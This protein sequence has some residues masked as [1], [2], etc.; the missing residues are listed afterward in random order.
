MKTELSKEEKALGAIWKV[1]DI[2]MLGQKHLARIHDILAVR[3]GIVGHSK[4]Q[5]L[6]REDDFRDMVLAYIKDQQEF[7]S[8]SVTNAQYAGATAFIKDV[9]KAALPT[10]TV[11]DQLSAAGRDLAAEPLPY[12]I[13][14][15]RSVK[16]GKDIWKADDGS[17][18]SFAVFDDKVIWLSG[19]DG[20]GNFTWTR[21]IF[22]QLIFAYMTHVFGEGSTNSYRFGKCIENLLSG[23]G[24]AVNG[25][26]VP[27]PKQPDVHNWSPKPDSLGRIQALAALAKESNYIKAVHP[28]T[29]PTDATDYYTMF[30]PKKHAYSRGSVLTN[31][32]NIMTVKAVQNL[33]GYK[34]ED[35]TQDQRTDLY[36][37]ACGGELKK[38]K[39]PA[40]VGQYVRQISSGALFRV[41][42]SRYTEVLL[43]RVI[44]PVRGAPCVVGQRTMWCGAHPLKTHFIPVKHVPEHYAACTW[45][46][47]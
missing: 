46:K 35:K 34:P 19:L 23:I 15:Q 22:E 44:E 10:M 21:E 8:T 42:E 12:G 4:G 13:Y 30:D 33:M 31:I 28:L 3:E 43:E 27:V 37:T 14:K 5:L 40:E 2:S 26:I 7:V 9:Y 6:F 38:P 36:L 47:E 17:C 16:F 45:D 39:F 32:G 11:N 24:K 20:F 18:D 25:K 41:I 1:D 29:R